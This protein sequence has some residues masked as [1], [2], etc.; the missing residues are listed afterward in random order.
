MRR[1]PFLLALGLAS[2]AIARPAGAPSWA[3]WVGDWDGKARWVSCTHDGE[4]PAAIAID[5]TD[6]AVAVDLGGMGHGL[7]GM[8]LVEDNAGWVGQQ[9]DVTVH[10]GHAH[11]DALDV[12]L[13]LDSGCQARA[14]LH[15]ATVGIPQCDRLAAWARIESRC[16]KLSK[17]ALENPARL[18]RQHAQWAKAKGDARTEL[19]TQCE[20]RS[21]KVEAEL[22]DAG[23][24]PSPD[25]GIGLRGAECQALRQVAG[26]V[27][28]CPSMPADLRSL[29]ARDAYDLAAMTQTA[30]T[31]SALQA[32]ENQ[33]KQ[34]RER[35]AAEAKNVG[36]PP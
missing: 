4:Q 10:L 22:V 12:E 5:A 30:D 20:A 16:T 18:V 17:P 19:A 33:C 9:A 11:G 32:I 13:D 14:T 26:R 24:A 3:D 31:A 35:L 25:P 23:C 7:G 2:G 8:S 28:R 29:L 1:W 27:E 6:G 15:R 36:C 21:S 34:M